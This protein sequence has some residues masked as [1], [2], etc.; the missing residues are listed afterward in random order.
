MST[1]DPDEDPA[2]AAA[3]AQLEA[4]R[5]VKAIAAK[6]LA[7][8]RSITIQNEY[9]KI[10]HQ[11]KSKRRSSIASHQE[12][13]QHLGSLLTK[14]IEL[15][16]K[17]VASHNHMLNQERLIKKQA[18]MNE[19]AIQLRLHSTT[20]KW[21]FQDGPPGESSLTRQINATHTYRH[22]LIN[23]DHGEYLDHKHKWQMT[24]PDR[25][26]W[27]HP[28]RKV[29]WKPAG[30]FGSPRAKEI[31]PFGALSPL[32]SYPDRDYEQRLRGIK[33]GRSEQNTYAHQENQASEDDPPSKYLPSGALIPNTPEN[34]LDQHHRFSNGGLATS[35]ML[36]R[37][38]DEDRILV[39]TALADIR[40]RFELKGG[41]QYADMR[42]F[43]ERDMSEKEFKEQLKKHLNIHLSKK[44]IH[45]VF[46]LID[47]DGSGYLSWLELL[48]KLYG[49]MDD[50]NMSKALETWVPVL[51][52]S[53]MLD[54][55]KTRWTPAHLPF[56][57]LLNPRIRPLFVMTD[58]QYADS[59]R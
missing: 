30:G 16:K 34:A 18:Q 38:A 5:S 56:G 17:S 52:R 42:A 49:N 11:T 21:R 23:Q 10:S 40:W 4:E 13:K 8:K 25:Q 39:V 59:I 32:S 50:T 51:T 28:E 45:L 41:R 22:D 6:Q 29:P 53:Q 19:N 47:R 31:T 54:D 20:H 33:K 24:A 48:P 46:E 35:V 58:E 1:L 3:K 15:K 7:R 55:N 26:L 27:A 9:R 37:M 57:S 36:D 2:A 12:F 43:D 14:S 44:I